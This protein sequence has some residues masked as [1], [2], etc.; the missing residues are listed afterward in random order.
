MSF[1]LLL[2]NEDQIQTDSLG[3]RFRQISAILYSLSD[4]AA[5]KFDILHNVY[6]H[7]GL[8]SPLYTPLTHVSSFSSSHEEIISAW[9]VHFQA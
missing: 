7:E 9:L 3:L 6:M 5:L 8:L 4:H 2:C 1:F